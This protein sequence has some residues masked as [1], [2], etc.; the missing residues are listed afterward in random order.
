MPK[1]ISKD[2]REKIV[3]AYE[4]N[5]GTAL[6]VANI[7]GVTER[8]V[9]KYLRQ[10]KETGDL[11]PIPNPGRPPV[12][13]NEN[14]AIIKDIILSNN[15]GTLEEFRDKFNE[16]TN[17]NVTIVT[18]FNATKKLKFKRKKKVSLQQSRKEKMYKQKEQII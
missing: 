14:L 4:R 11:S 1:A 10:N 2:V 5:V 12:L 9:F 15:D 3:S 7:F 16:I 17:S 13:T 18:I 6:E 8:T